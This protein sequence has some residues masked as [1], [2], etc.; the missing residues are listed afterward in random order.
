M[1]I[2]KY[3]AG[4]E[5]ELKKIFISSIRENATNYYTP[6]QLEAWAPLEF[7]ENK[8]KERIQGINPYVIIERDEILGYADLQTN[9]YVDHFFVKGGHSGKGIGSELMEW[10]I[11]SAKDQNITELSSDV[12]LAAQGLFTKFGFDIVK[13]KKVMING[14]ELE[15]AL[16]KKEILC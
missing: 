1:L 3:K 5:N 15:N 9:G 10:I 13:R 4:E 2:R 12:S 7:D 16:M 11:V 14:I 6:D 8:W